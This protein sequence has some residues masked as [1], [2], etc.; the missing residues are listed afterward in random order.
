MVERKSCNCILLTGLVV[1]VVILGNSFVSAG[2]LGPM[3]VVKSGTDRALDI[4]KEQQTPQGQKLRQRRG[5][6]L[7]IVDQYFNFQEMARRALGRPWKDQPPEKQKEFVRLFK[8]LLFNTYVDRVESYTG[9]D[10]R[11]LYDEERIEGDY[12]RVRT[13]V[14]NYKTS[15]VQVE[16]RL[17][18]ENGEWKVYDVVVEGISFIDNYR[19]QFSSILAGESFDSLLDRLR[20]KVRENAIL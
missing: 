15:D 10:E 7:Q 14:S 9:G 1:F 3:G 8:D 18:Q 11:V 16:Y 6:I 19:S 17:R 12:A 20:Q 2:A 5:E 4:L 13:R